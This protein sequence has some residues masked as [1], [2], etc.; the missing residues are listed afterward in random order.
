MAKSSNVSSD[1]LESIIE[2]E[3]EEELNNPITEVENKDM[4]L[5][6]SFLEQKKVKKNN[7]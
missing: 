2:Q 4:N 1:E 6:N 7:Y 3:S 5:M